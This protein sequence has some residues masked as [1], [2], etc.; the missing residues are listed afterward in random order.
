MFQQYQLVVLLKL[1]DET[2]QAAKNISDLFQYHN[3]QI[4]QAAVNVIQKTGG[5]GVFLLFEGYDELP[6][7]LCTKRSVIL[8]VITRKK[9]PEAT[10]LI[11]SHPWATELLHR[12]HKEHLS[13]H[14]KIMGFTKDS[15]H[16]YLESITSN[17]PHLAGLMK[18]ISCYPHINSLMHI[19]LFSSIVV[20]VYQNSSKDKTLIPKTMTDLYFSLVHY[21]LQC[22][23]SDRDEMWALY[24]LSDLPDKIY[25]QLCGLGRI[26]Y[27]GI[28]HDQ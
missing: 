14:F 25:Q 13:H 17:D 8:D 7:K 23:L 18:Y 15:I 1:C 3:H 28:L 9:L 11:T 24:S 20:E 12:K 21:V 10:V 16:L 27:E 26:E 2:V 6:K 19:P 4:Q 22:Y 5:K